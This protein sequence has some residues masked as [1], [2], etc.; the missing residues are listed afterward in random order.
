[1]AIYMHMVYGNRVRNNEMH[2]AILKLLCTNVHYNKMM[3][4]AQQL[5]L[6]VHSRYCTWYMYLE[7]AQ[8]TV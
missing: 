2:E 8:Y 5:G 7:F 6:H 4:H 3:C 1:M